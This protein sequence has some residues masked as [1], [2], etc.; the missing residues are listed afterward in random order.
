MQLYVRGLLLLNGGSL[1]VFFPSDVIARFDI[2]RPRLF[3][4][5]QPHAS[6]NLERGRV[7]RRKR[8]KKMKKDQNPK[9]TE[10]RR[11]LIGRGAKLGLEFG[12]QNPE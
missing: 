2:E 8:K 4:P 7:V 11:G 5:R 1:R 3:C 9:V 10:E 12:V 6:R